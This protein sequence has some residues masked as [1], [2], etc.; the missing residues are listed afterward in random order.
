[1]KLPLGGVSYEIG[2]FLIEEDEATRKDV[3]R[4]QMSFLVG[5]N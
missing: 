2:L 3:Q 1:M 4:I 5:V